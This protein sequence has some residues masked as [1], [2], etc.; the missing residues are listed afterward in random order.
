MSL[1]EDARRNRA[2]WDGKSDEYQARLDGEVFEYQLPYGGWIRL[3][4]ANGLDVEDL[5]E[6]RP[7][8]DATS[9]YWDA[10]ELEWPR[11]WPSESIWKARKRG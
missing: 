9:T 7:A 5:I 2:F 11:R 1:S 6:P 10:A 3:F 8:E 4:R